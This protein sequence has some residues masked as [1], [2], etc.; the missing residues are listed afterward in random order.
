METNLQLLLDRGLA[1]RDTLKLGPI[2]ASVYFG[3]PHSIYFQNDPHHVALMLKALIDAHPDGTDH[4][5]IL[6]SRAHTA[7]IAEQ[8]CIEWDTMSFGA[9]TV[10]MKD[11]LAVR[12]HNS[13]DLTDK[14][15][16]EYLKE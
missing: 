1:Y 13:T 16:M 8:G 11:W 12:L 3:D 10:S 14:W 7:Q 4:G 9:G 2:Y 5:V 15:L 6:R